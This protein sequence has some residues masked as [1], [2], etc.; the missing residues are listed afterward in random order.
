MVLTM[1][2]MLFFNLPILFLAPSIL[3]LDF[4]FVFGYFIC[5]G[6][7]GLVWYEWRSALSNWQSV[8]KA[9]KCD[10]SGMIWLKR[11]ALYNRIQMEIDLNNN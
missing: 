1:F 11:E 6:L 3:N 2:G 5:I 10:R 8:Q 7:I 9:K 4:I